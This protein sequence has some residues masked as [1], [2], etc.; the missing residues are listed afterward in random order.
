MLYEVITV[1]AILDLSGIE[2]G[3]HRLIPQIQVDERPSRIVT[4]DPASVLVKLEPLIR[5]SFTVQPAISGQPAVGYQAGDL[6]LDPREI[7][8]SGPQFV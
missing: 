3:E 1:R 7:V 6:E 5:K 2:E 8:V 4:V